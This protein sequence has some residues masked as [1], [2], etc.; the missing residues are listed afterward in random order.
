MCW[1]YNHETCDL[2]TRGGKEQSAYCFCLPRGHHFKMS[3]C[4]CEFLS[5]PTLT[6]S[7]HPPLD[8][9]WRQI[10]WF[11]VSQWTC[12]G[13]FFIW[14]RERRKSTSFF[15]AWF[16]QPLQNGS[17]VIVLCSWEMIWILCRPKW[18]K[19]IFGLSVCVWSETRDF[20]ASSVFMWI[21][22]VA[23]LPLLLYLLNLAART[24]HFCDHVFIILSI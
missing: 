18:E 20:K 11:P 12:K 4:G 10:R 5:A 13:E 16:V 23:K 21:T 1:C 22:G 15:C 14:E 19:T 24:R 6:T 2:L 8:S 3:C 17:S 7:P 9:V